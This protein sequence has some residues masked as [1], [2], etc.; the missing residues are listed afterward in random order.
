MQQATKLMSICGSFTAA[1][2]ASSGQRTTAAAVAA[3][4]DG[5]VHGGD[6]EEDRAEEIV[7]VEA[8]ASALL[9]RQQ[10]PGFQ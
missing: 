10:R 5:A 7:R 6:D 8:I 2:A 9:P 3:A 4:A 1:A